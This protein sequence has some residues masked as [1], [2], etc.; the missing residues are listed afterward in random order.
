MSGHLCTLKLN[1]LCRCPIQLRPVRKETVKYYMLRDSIRDL[2]IL[3]PLL[4]RP[5]GD[6]YEVVAGNHRL[7]CARDLQLESLPCTIRE[8][9][10]EEVLRI[11]EIENLNRIPTNA[12]DHVRRLQ[13]IINTGE[14]SVEELAYEIHVHPDWVRR[15]L[16]LNCLSPEWKDRLAEGTTSI[17]IGAEV[18]K[19]PLGKQIDLL[20]VVGDYS[21]KEFLELVRGV[22][23]DHRT[24]KQRARHQYTEG[25]KPHARQWRTYEDEYLNHTNAATVLMRAN[26]ETALDGWVAAIEWF[27]SMDAASIEERTAR[28]KRAENLA[29][30]KNEQRI[31]EL[32]ER[33]D[34]Q[35]IDYTEQLD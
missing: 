12:V 19:L 16:S 2:G 27:L 11:Q 17:T 5:N 33:K 4:V 9:S 13:K 18:A 6:K 31:L 32:K 1:D 29:D 26:A 30:R 7:E 25:V 3:Q 24:N 15:L 34:E 10:D 20:T 8:M 14:K 21:S 22:V 28:K 35:S 23:R